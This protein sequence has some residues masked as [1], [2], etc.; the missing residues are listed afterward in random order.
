M[1]NNQ[2]VCEME[3]ERIIKDIK[4]K[5][6]ECLNKMSISAKNIILFGSRAR[7][8]SSKYSDYD[9]LIITEKTFNIKEKMEI[10]KKVNQILA[11]LL[12]PSDI[13]INSEE[14]VEYK[15]NR[16]G[17]VAR[18]ALKEGIKI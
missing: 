13:I 11:K 17:C 2:D 4:E 7:G 15:K 16:I 3:N 5:I 10:N 8:D 1:A 14:E 18:Y 12:I 6:V 9:F